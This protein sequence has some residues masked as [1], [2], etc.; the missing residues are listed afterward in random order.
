MKCFIAKPLYFSVAIVC[1]MLL[2][3][4]GSSNET[5]KETQMTN[6]PTNKQEDLTTQ[7]SSIDSIDFEFDETPSE[8]SYYFQEDDIVAPNYPIVALEEA[9]RNGNVSDVQKWLDKGVSPLWWN[10]KKSIGDGMDPMKVKP[11][12]V[13]LLIEAGADPKDFEGFK[14]AGA[15][16]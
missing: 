5:P 9:V 4:C 3:G 15:K 16:E 8:L 1:G 7:G 10:W 11:E 2:S 6:K 14:S 13:T 12:I